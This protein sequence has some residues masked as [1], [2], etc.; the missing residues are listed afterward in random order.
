M[1][2]YDNLK[3]KAKRDWLEKGRWMVPLFK[4]MKEIEKGIR[5][6]DDKDAKNRLRKRFNKYYRQAWERQF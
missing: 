4:R 2:A 5:A 6:T 3:G 1:A